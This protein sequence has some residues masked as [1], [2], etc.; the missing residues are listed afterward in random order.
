MKFINKV[1]KLLKEY[2][3]INIILVDVLSI[4]LAYILTYI[5]IPQE[6]GILT[7]AFINTILISVATYIILFTVCKVYINIKE[8]T[9]LI[10]ICIIASLIVS[11]VSK[12]LPI[13]MLNIKTN[14]LATIFI[15]CEIISIRV[16]TNKKIIYGIGENNRCE[17]IE[18]ENLLGRERVCLNNSEISKYIKDKVVLV[19]GAGGSIGSELCRQIATFSPKVLIMLD[20]YENTLYEVEQELQ[21]IYGEDIIKSVVASIRDK[22]RMDEVFGKYRPQIVFHAAA[23]KHVP[24]MENS[25]TEAIKNNVFGTYN[26]VECADK[27]EVD[28]FVLISTDKAVNPTSIMG[29]TKR[30]CEMIVQSRN[31]KSKTNYVAVRFGNI[32]GSNGSVIPLFKKQI[33]QGGPVTV[34]H[35]EITRYFML[36][37]EAV[38]L[39]LQ[40]ATYAKGGEIFVLDMGKPIKVY[41]LAKM[42]IKVSGKNIPIKII[43]LRKGEKL[44][45]ELLTM[46]EGLTKTAHNKIMISKIEQYD[47]KQLEEN[48]QKLAS[49]I[50]KEN[51]SR[52]DV[53][54]LMKQIVPTF[55]DKNIK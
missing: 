12:V 8:Y 26:I 40:A 52:E 36:I 31:T 10:G 39:I 41:N 23:H 45:E 48:L 9:K 38:G 28:R 13:E 15:I 30:I 16:V 46:E 17:D 42:L 51:C 3:T 22:K 44:Y 1:I 43:G 18:L 7:S 21:P 53:R 2:K 34:T 24:L 47:E 19:T 32:L 25:A 20:I 27:Y 49:L 37:T 55:T 54:S 5:F 6:Y 35:K 50:E 11:I 14:I 33:A 29:A 4:I